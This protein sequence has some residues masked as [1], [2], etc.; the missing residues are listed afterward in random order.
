MQPLQKYAMASFLSFAFAQQETPSS[1]KKVAQDNSGYL[2]DDRS[3]HVR[4]TLKKE[5]M[6]IES[7]G[8]TE[9]C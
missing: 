5:L 9:V 7:E 1:I 8:S 6:L 2:S 4:A 3:N